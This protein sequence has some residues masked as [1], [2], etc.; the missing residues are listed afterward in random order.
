VLPHELLGESEHDGIH[1][2]THRR[3][4]AREP[5]DALLDERPRRQRTAAPLAHARAA[6]ASQRLA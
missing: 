3:C 5:I 1:P 6:A 2:V 4:R